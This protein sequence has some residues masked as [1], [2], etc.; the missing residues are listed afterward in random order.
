MPVFELGIAL[1]GPQSTSSQ[2]AFNDS[3][4]SF[5]RPALEANLATPKNTFR[6]S[7]TNFCIRVSAA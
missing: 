5:L 3:T 7:L 2:N 6:S 4:L 1:S